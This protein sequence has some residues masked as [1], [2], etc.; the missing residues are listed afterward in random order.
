MGFEA[1]EEYSDTAIAIKATR[2]DNN[3]NYKNY[4]T[5]EPH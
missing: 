4:I 3:K 1:E 2:L 5:N